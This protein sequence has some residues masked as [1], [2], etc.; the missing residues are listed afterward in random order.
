MRA[1]GP[2]GRNVIE[3]T[4]CN[5]GVFQHEFLR[6]SAQKNRRPPHSID[7]LVER[8]DIPPAFRAVT[9]IYLKMRQQIISDRYGS[10][11]SGAQT[12]GI[13]WRFIASHYP[14][15]LDCRE[16]RSEHTR[17]FIPF[18]VEY[19]RERVRAA[20]AKSSGANTAQHRLV[21]V[22]TFFS[23]LGHWGAEVDS[24]L[25]PYVPPVNPFSYRKLRILQFTS[26]KRRLAD[27][28]QSRMIEFE[29][30][31]PH[32]R[33]LTLRTWQTAEQSRQAQP[34]NMRIVAAERRA[35]WEW[36]LLELLLQSGL[37]IEEACEL[38]T[39]DILK[40][41]DSAGAV[42]YLLHI[43]PSKFDRARVIPIGDSLGRVIAEMIRHVKR[44]HNSDHVPFCTRWD[45]HER[46][47]QARAPYLLQAITGP[48]VISVGSL[49][50]RIVQASRRAD[51][52]AAD[53]SPLYLRPHDCRRLFATEH[54][55]N[56]VPVHII[57]AL[58]GHESVDTTM[59][60]AKLYPHTLIAEY[61]GALRGRYEDMSG[62]EAFRAPTLAEWETFS[63]SCNLR[64][65]GAHLCAL[66]AG[67]HCARGLVCLGC[68][69][70]Q[71]KRSALPVFERMLASHQTSLTRARAV[72]EPAG[73]IAARELELD[74]IR[75][76]AQRAR[77]LP[78]DVASALEAVA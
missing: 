33:A 50:D 2:T 41:H 19:C 27:A 53:G 11:M 37:R 72:P 43:K 55:N 32:I 64:D 24:P 16:V 68:S 39:L 29:R 71:P 12:L 35:F 25:H 7:F 62:K 49:R 60:Y 73:Q 13:F 46:K 51:T 56:H 21:I 67:A 75:S 59:I 9:R 47:I 77:E 76:A 63:R 6:T 17:A 52:S 30:V 58:L 66:P 8:A 3:A 20:F 54:L 61:R 26:T 74:R 70:A 78:S 1:K 22:C 36:A 69:H 10:V 28:T 45:H 15:V 4:L 65:M 14:E 23:D 34:A 38:T 44:F 57:Q 18:M 40:R 48:N 31:L 42:Y 5:L